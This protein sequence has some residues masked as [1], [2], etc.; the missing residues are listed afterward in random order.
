MHAGPMGIW[1]DPAHLPDCEMGRLVF[2]TRVLMNAWGL[3]RPQQMQDW[4]PG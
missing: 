3:V 2:G 4:R 1:A